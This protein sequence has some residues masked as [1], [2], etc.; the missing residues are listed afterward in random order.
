MC[1]KLIDNHECKQ[2]GK[3]GGYC[4]KHRHDYLIQDD[5]ICFQRYTGK[6]SDYL[7]KNMFHTIIDFYR[8]GTLDISKLRK[9]DKKNI[10]II[11]DNMIRRVK[12][13]DHEEDKIIKIQ[14]YFKKMNEIRMIQLHGEGYKNHK[15]C[16]NDIDFY[17]FDKIDDISDHYFFSYQDN[18]DLVWFFD[19]RSFDK[20]IRMNQLENPYTRQTI[21]KDVIERG[22]QLI[23]LLKSRGQYE[24]M[25]IDIK[26]NRKET[27]K[28]KTVDLCS[29]IE[30]FGYECNIQWFLNLNIRRIKKLYRILEDIWNFRL[31]LTQ[32]LKNTIAPPNGKV[33]STPVEDVR[34]YT[35]LEDVQ[36]LILS[37]VMK[38]N[39]AERD[40][41]K[42]LGYMYFIMG[43]GAI[44]NQCLDAH[45][46]ILY[47]GI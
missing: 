10:F 3:Y 32:E 36:D 21:P 4:Y 19:I 34:L 7:K 29:Q 15:L 33:F 45:P 38:F 39:G 26:R 24:N 40:S 9:Y 12:A 17:S 30:Q 37:D 28:Q 46:W 16:N 47:A 42:K 31:Q 22:N 25:D 1:K 11:L 13:Y 35:S 20:L 6:Q 27:I 14:Q 23:Q 2:K 43:L 8:D 41:D 5:K 44:S 18:N